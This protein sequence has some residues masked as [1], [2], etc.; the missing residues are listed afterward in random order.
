MAGCKLLTRLRHTYSVIVPDGKGPGDTILVYA[1][2]QR[3]SVKVPPGFYQGS[4]FIISVQGTHYQFVSHPVSYAIPEYT[5]NVQ[6][7]PRYESSLVSLWILLAVLIMSLLVA[8]FSQPYFAQQRIS[9]GCQ[10]TNPN[11]GAVV[12]QMWYILYKV[13]NTISFF[14]LSRFCSKTLSN[15]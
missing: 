7:I 14:S 13:I 3:L 15:K 4:S 2:K 8:S 9:S 10:A 11:T 1:G 6:T 5:Y 12:T